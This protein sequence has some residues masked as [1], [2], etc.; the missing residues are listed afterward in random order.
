MLR[1]APL[2]RT[3]WHP[4]CSCSYSFA[5]VPESAAAPQ[6][7]LALGRAGEMCGVRGADRSDHVV[8]AEEKLSYQNRLTGSCCSQCVHRR[9]Q[10]PS[11]SHGPQPLPS[12]AMPNRARR[13]ERRRARI[14]TTAATQ[15]C[16]RRT[17]RIH[18]VTTRDPTMP[19]LGGTAV[20][21]AAACQPSPWRR[22][23]WSTAVLFGHIGAKWHTKARAYCARAWACARQ[24]TLNPDPASAGHS[25]ATQ[26][27][28]R[29][30]VTHKH[31]L[32]RLGVCGDA[33]RSRVRHRGASSTRSGR[34]T[35]GV[36]PFR[37]NTASRRLCNAVHEAAPCHAAVA[38]LTTY[39]FHTGTRKTTARSHATGPDPRAGKQLA[40]WA[41]R[42]EHPRWVSESLT[43]IFAS[44]FGP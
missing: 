37:C 14:A 41:R 4:S 38:H 20:G 8:Y 43:P 39:R 40:F 36:D 31:G 25:A 10:E 32:A 35:R 21:R 13:H 2:T 22:F 12:S 1:A 11:D 18:E 29:A 19:S 27:C 23:D 3:T 30:A 9:R 7:C 42:S 33:M 28:I 34:H 5:L 15:V 26:P 44:F 16:N 17:S 24:R 6:N